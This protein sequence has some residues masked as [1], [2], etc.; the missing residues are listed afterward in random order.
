MPSFPHT[1]LLPRRASAADAGSQR[2]VSSLKLRGRAI[3]AP[4]AF[5]VS[6]HFWPSSNIFQ[7]IPVLI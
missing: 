6:F 5:L 2:L 3:Q 7:H 4:R 1:R